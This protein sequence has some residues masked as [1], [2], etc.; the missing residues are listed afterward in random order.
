MADGVDVLEFDISTQEAMIAATVAAESRWQAEFELEARMIAQSVNAPQGLGVQGA[1]SD[2]SYRWGRKKKKQA[3]FS[4]YRPTM[5]VREVVLEYDDL[6]GRVTSLGKWALIGRWIF[7][8][9][10]EVD[11]ME[12]AKKFWCPIVGYTPKV[13]FLLNN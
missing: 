13:S 10:N 5:D 7:A 1:P 4:Y 2:V 6:W 12:W 11:M 8:E 9:G 3:H